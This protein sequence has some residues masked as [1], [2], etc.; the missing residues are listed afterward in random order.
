MHVSMNIKLE[1][2][3]YCYVHVLLPFLHYDW[4]DSTPDYSLGDQDLCLI[5][6]PNLSE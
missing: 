6:V 2:N 1:K 3:V 5:F 4:V